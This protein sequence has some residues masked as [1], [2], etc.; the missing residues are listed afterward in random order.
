MKGINKKMYTK[1]FLFID[2]NN[3]CT[4]TVIIMLYEMN[5]V[6]L[7]IVSKRSY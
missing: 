4:C 6:I 1:I 7:M 5:V 2:A 3:Y